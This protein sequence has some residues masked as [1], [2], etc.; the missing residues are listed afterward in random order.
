MPLIVFGEELTPLLLAPLLKPGIDTV[1]VA[2]V[3]RDRS[4]FHHC[5]LL[6]HAKL[7]API[8]IAVWCSS[9]VLRLPTQVTPRHENHFL[10]VFS[11]ISRKL[12]L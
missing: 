7:A 1:R 8:T 6:L 12:L 10:L 9:H 11:E 3:P 5:H 2:K 4:V